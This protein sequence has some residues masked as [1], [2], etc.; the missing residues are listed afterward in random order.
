MS[1]NS[2]VTV[3][4]SPSISSVAW[5]AL[6]NRR[7]AWL[8]AGR[9]RGA[10]APIAAPHSPHNLSPGWTPAPHFGQHTTRGLPQFVQNLPPSRLSLPHFE[11]RMLTRLIARYFLEVAQALACDVLNKQPL[12]AVRMIDETPLNRIL[13]DVLEFLFQFH[14]VPDNVVEIFIAPY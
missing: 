13:S 11:Q 6:L 10:D 9:D 1:A 2:A 4:R 12:V 5:T 8:C 3:L 7:G 14:R